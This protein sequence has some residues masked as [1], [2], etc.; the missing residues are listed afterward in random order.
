VQAATVQAAQPA[1]QGAPAAGLMDA[2]EDDH[3]FSVAAAGLPLVP[4]GAWARL[5]L[6]GLAVSAMAL[7]ALWLIPE[8]AA[9]RPRPGHAWSR[10]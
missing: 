1:M 8:P 2:P 3:A 6:G 10:P 4:G 7:S 5:V 9:V